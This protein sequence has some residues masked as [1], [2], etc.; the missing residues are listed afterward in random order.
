MVQFANSSSVTLREATEKRN[1]RLGCTLKEF[2]QDEHVLSMV[3]VCGAKTAA[4]VSTYSGDAFETVDKSTE[5]GVTTVIRMKGRR[6]GD[7]K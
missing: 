7:C 5:A 2:K 4:I 1:A 6:T 3:N